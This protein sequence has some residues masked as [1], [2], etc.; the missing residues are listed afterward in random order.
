LCF[1]AGRIVAAVG[2]LTSGKLV[3]HYGG[4]PQM[5]AVITLVYVAGLALVW[6]APETRGRSLP[7]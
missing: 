1:N 2:A 6:L 4:Y 7:E 5:G 3:A